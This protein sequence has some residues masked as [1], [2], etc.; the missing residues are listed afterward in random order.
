MPPLSTGAKVGIGLG[1]WAVLLYLVRKPVGTAVS[2]GARFVTEQIDSKLQ[3][4]LHAVAKLPKVPTTVYALLPPGPPEIGPLRKNVSPQ[5]LA[6]YFKPKV[7]P[8]LAEVNTILKSSG[9]SAKLGETVRTWIRQTYLYGI[10]RAYQAPGRTGTV[11]N[12]LVATGMHPRGQAVDFDYFIGGTYAGSPELS[13]KVRAAL[14]PHAARLEAK[15]GVQWGGKWAKPDV[16][17]WED[18]A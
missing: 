3:A 13:A 5:G 6:L 18:V 15:Y 12:V 9:M 7:E 2:T 17:H 11:T 16:P 14:L 1:L 4:L 8:L 10:G